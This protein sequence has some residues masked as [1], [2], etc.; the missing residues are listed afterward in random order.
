MEVLQ[1]RFVQEH[2][3]ELFTNLFQV[4]NKTQVGEIR[5]SLAGWLLTNYETRNICV[6][7][8]KKLEN[9]ETENMISSKVGLCFFFAFVE[10]K[11]K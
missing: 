3:E 8:Q 9:L 2:D 6:K 10:C 7:I 1:L 4:I 5:I 11:G